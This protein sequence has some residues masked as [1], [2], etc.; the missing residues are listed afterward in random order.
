MDKYLKT[1]KSLWNGWQI[2]YKFPN[3]YGA[4]VVQHHYSYG[5][6]LAVIEWLDDDHWE[7]C[8]TTPITDNVIGYLEFETLYPILEQIYELEAGRW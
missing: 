5:M 2:L 7:L 8:K 3:G 6:E 1:T 4:S